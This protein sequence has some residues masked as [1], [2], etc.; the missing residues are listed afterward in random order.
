MKKHAL[1]SG[2]AG[3]IGSHLVDR[4]LKEFELVTVID[5]FSTGKMKNLALARETGRLQILQGDICDEVF[6]QS[7]FKYEEVDQV[8]HLATHCVRSSIHDPVRNHQ[9]NTTGT[10]NLLIASHRA[11]VK[12]FIYCSSSEVFGDALTLSQTRAL[13]EDDL[14]KPT[15]IYGASK[16]AGEHYTEAFHKTYGLPVVIVRP[17]NA[18]GP[19]SHLVGPRGEVIPRFFYFAQHQKP[20]PI[21]GQGEQTRDFSYV[22]DIVEGIVKAAQCDALEGTVIH[23]GSGVETSVEALARKIESCLHLSCER[24]TYPQRLGEVPRL[25]ADITRAKKWLGFAPKVSLEHGLEKTWEWLQKQPS[26]S[27]SVEA[28]NWKPPLFQ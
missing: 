12:R 13:K 16:L 9:V 25:W 18:Y 22:T 3:F 23:L 17:F 14:K 20:F 11:K 2:G 27:Q 5:D 8:Y 19:R 10:L 21:F 6:L 26:P 1:V 15:T 4:L 24:E 7:Q 28:S